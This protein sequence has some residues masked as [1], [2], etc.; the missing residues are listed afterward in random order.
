MQSIFEKGDVSEQLKSLQECYEFEIFV[1]ILDQCI[2][3]MDIEYDEI[4][5]ETICQQF[6]IIQRYFGL[7]D[8]DDIVYETK[9]EYSE[10]DYIFNV[11]EL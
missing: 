6:P 8:D 3:E 11:N 1:Q 7:D 10:T 4:C 2:D 5:F 9:T